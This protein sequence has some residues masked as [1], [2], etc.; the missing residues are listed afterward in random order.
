MPKQLLALNHPDSSIHSETNQLLLCERFTAFLKAT[1]LHDGLNKQTKV[2]LE[3]YL[4]I[5]NHY[6]N[7]KTPYVVVVSPPNNQLGCCE[8]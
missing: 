6:Q 1:T 3:K 8:N 2:R 5:K 7:T 4:N